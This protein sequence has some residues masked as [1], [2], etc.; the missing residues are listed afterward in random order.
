MEVSGKL[1]ERLGAHQRVFQEYSAGGASRV[2]T[3][4]TVL[5]LVSKGNRAAI[6]GRPPRWLYSNKYDTWMSQM[7][8]LKNTGDFGH[9]SRKIFNFL[10]VRGIMCDL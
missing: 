3:L 4:F 1:N 9:S 5:V 7:D 10:F 8:E 2:T 6:L